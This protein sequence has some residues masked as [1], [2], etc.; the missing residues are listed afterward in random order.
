MTRPPFGGD[1]LRDAEQGQAH[2]G[3]GV[4]VIGGNP[5]IDG[6]FK[7]RP[8]GAV[9]IR[10]AG[11]VD[12]DFDGSAK[13]GD[14]LFMH[15]GSA[16]IGGEGADGDAGDL[17]VPG[18]LFGAFAVAAMDDNGAAFLGQQLGDADADA[19]A[20]AGDQDAFSGK[21]KIHLFPLC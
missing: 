7:R 1:H 20:A 21:L 18:S 15:R 16:F 3:E 19:A 5:F 17:N 9:A 14:G 4:V 13:G 10:A 8:V 6:D 11:I 12:E 2:G